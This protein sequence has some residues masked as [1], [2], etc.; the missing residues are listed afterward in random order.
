[1]AKRYNK[2][3]FLGLQ[4]LDLPAATPSDMH[5]YFVAYWWEDGTAHGCGSYV[6]DLESPV[7]SAAHVTDLHLRAWDDAGVTSEATIH[8]I[9]IIR[10]DTL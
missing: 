8:V 3:A 10:L 5:R 4:S 9:N 1:M 7:R 2:E 6:A